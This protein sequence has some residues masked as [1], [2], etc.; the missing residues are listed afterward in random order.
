MDQNDSAIMVLLLMGEHKRCGELRPAQ[1][2]LSALCHQGWSHL[3]LRTLDRA[4]E[5]FEKA[6]KLS[7]SDFE[8]NL[9]MAKFYEAKEELDK[10]LDVL[11]RLVIK[12]PDSAVPIVEKMGLHLSLCDWEQAMEQA[13]R[14][15]A[16][17][18]AAKV[19]VL[20]ALC[21]DGNFE[22]AEHEIGKLRRILEEKENFNPWAY[23][24][25]AQLITR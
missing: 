13:G 7:P 10:A 17:V 22:E 25:C 23:F 24:N 16:S 11:N 5:C 1:Q 4:Q 6:L 19:R 15:Q 18:E 8:A 21:L 12:H 3:Q 2:S 9:G 14:V 20:K